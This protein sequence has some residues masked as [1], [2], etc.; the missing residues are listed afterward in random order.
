MEPMAL[1]S[2]PSSPSSPTANPN[3]YLPSFLLG[4]NEPS[5]TPTLPSEFRKNESYS[6]TPSDRSNL[7]QKLFSPRFSESP[8]QSLYD[9]NENKPGP[10]TQSLFDTIDVTRSVNTASTKHN[11]GKSINEDKPFEENESFAFLND[12]FM[13]TC[14]NQWV[15]VYGFPTSAANKRFPAQGN[16]VH[17]KYNSSVEASKALSLNGKLISNNIMVGV[18]LYQNKGCDK[19]NKDI[20]YYKSP[21]RARSLRQSFVSPQASN[22]VV[23]P[24]SVPHKS[25]GLVTKAM[26][27]VFGW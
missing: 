7:R 18:C 6:T 20:S 1:G 8:M 25:N 2:A 23:T 15:T 5:S 3:Y 26:E 13:G 9:S 11:F 19:E 16:W 27:Y 10:P 14:Q 24:T 4:D 22:T 21:G 17:L 12:S